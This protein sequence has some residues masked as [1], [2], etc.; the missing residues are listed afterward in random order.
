VVMN[1]T[2]IRSTIRDSVVNADGVAVSVLE[3]NKGFGGYNSVS[4][5]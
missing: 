2:V 3:L 5:Q 4:A 1:V